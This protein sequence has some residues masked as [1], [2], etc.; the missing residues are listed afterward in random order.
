MRYGST[1]Q[2]HR[3]ECFLS[4]GA[5]AVATAMPDRLLPIRIQKLP[6]AG[7]RLDMS[8]Q[9]DGGVDI[10]DLPAGVRLVTGHPGNPPARSAEQKDQ[11]H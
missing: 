4:R 2:H 3:H 10:G 9:K 8:V 5:E 6:L 1:W 7:A 11:S